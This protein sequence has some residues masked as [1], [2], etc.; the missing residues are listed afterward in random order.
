MKG[1][2]NKFYQRQVRQSCEKTSLY[3]N[4]LQKLVDASGDGK[5][6]RQDEQ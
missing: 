5:S 1:T 4:T 3:E 2:P 6:Y